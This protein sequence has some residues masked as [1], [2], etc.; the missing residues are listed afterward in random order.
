MLSIFEWPVRVYYEDTD[1]GGV[2][3]YANYLKYLERARSE[4]LRRLGVDQMALMRDSAIAFAVRRVEIDYLQPARL[5]DELTVEVVVESISRVSMTFRQ[6][7]LR[8]P[9]VLLASALA[10]VVCVNTDR[11]RPTGIPVE[12][13][14]KIKNAQQ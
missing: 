9:D 12:L 5:D 3:Y 14:E 6:R 8:G 1:A 13:L 11:F 4:A 2:V 7:I 10:Q